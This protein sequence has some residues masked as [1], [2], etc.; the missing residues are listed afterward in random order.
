MNYV[1]LWRGIMKSNKYGFSALQT[2][3][4][5]RTRAKTTYHFGISASGH[6]WPMLIRKIL[7]IACYSARGCTWRLEDSTLRAVCGLAQSD[8]PQIGGIAD[9]D[10]PKG[11]SR[12]N[13]TEIC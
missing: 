3:G 1:F 6:L 13:L 8:G 9:L 4:G 2:K 12:L 7:E 11:S 10:F 5:L